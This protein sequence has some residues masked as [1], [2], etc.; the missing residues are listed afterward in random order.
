MNRKILATILFILLAYVAEAQNFGHEFGGHV[1]DYTLAYMLARFF[2]LFLVVVGL[3]AFIRNDQEDYFDQLV[4]SKEFL[5][6]TGL[7]TVMLGAIVVA[8]NNTWKFEWRL[9][10][11]ILGW[12]TFLKGTMMLIFPGLSVSIWRKLSVKPWVLLTSGALSFIIG[13][14]LVWIGFRLR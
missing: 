7:I 1:G 2:G 13:I 5:F 11:T 10:I 9:L 12:V 3:M 6:I 14:Y 8:L 4:E